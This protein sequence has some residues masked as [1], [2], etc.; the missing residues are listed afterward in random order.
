M[1]VWT[2]STGTGYTLEQLVEEAR[3]VAE[4]IVLDY[5]DHLEDGHEDFSLLDFAVH[6]FG[7]GCDT[8]DA[9]HALYERDIDKACDILTEA[10][11]VK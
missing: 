8:E 11:T 5:A 4:S 9:W 2:D 10:D 6:T 3:I 1:I 7:S